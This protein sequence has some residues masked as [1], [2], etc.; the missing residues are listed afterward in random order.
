MISL[1]WKKLPKDVRKFLVLFSIT[2]F[3]FS[4]LIAAPTLG[5]LMNI[6]LE[7]VGWLFSLSSFLQALLS[8]FIGRKFEKLP[9]TYGLAISRGIFGIGSLLYGLCTSVWTFA[10]AQLF[11]SFADIFYPCLVMYERALFPPKQRENIY[12]L[13]F[14]MT[15][16]TKAIAYALFVFVFAPLMQGQSFLRSVFFMIFFA[17]LFYSAAYLFIL[18][19]VESG[20]TV[21]SEHVVAST[22]LKV[23]LSIML[24]QYLCFTA[25]NFSSFLI[26]SYYL[27]DLFKMPAWSP[28][29][30]EMV[31]SATVA[32]SIFWKGKVKSHPS[33]NLIFGASAIAANFL[34]WIIQN[35]VLFFASHVLMGIGFIFW[36]PAKETIKQQVAPRQLG[37]WEGFFQ[38]LNILTRIFT[39][40]ASATVAARVGYSFVFVISA[41]LF[42]AAIAIS[43]PS[44]LWMKKNFSTEQV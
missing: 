26:I 4:A 36:F 31:F 41:L 29:L 2:G 24:H 8:Y 18:P 25:F 9:P 22:G 30:F 11:L 43:M 16:S 44:V 35:P 39:P 7:S 12:S 10:V 27:I 21:H 17:N 37:R 42:F 28:F 14:F 1:T 5:N 32:S 34:I 38:G 33:F 6:S 3:S 23:F 20:S 19:R 40:V 13:E 15:E